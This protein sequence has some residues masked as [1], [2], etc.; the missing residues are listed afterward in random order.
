MRQMEDTEQRSSYN[1]IIRNYLIRTKGEQINSIETERRTT[2]LFI[3]INQ[4]KKLD[5]DATPTYQ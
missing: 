5:N 2:H 3:N 1:K 4:F